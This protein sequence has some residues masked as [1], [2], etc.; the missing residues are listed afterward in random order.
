[1]PP[2]V[3]EG[4]SVPTMRVC[5]LEGNCLSIPRD[6]RDKWLLDPIRSPT[7]KDV[8]RKFDSVFTAELVVAPQLT[9]AAAA[10]EESSEVVKDE[11]VFAWGD[12]F[13][14]AATTEQDLA[15]L[16]VVASF[17]LSV[18]GAHMNI[19]EEKELYVLASEELTLPV[20]VWL[21]G[22]GAG[23][24]LQDEKASTFLN[25]PSGTGWMKCEFNSD[26]DLI[27]FEEDADSHRATDSAPHTLR[28]RFHQI[29]SKGLV[30]IRLG[31][32]S[33]QRPAAVQQGQMADR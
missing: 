4:P 11:T 22:Y 24:W 15:K 13:P 3:V 17:P 27:I 23:M 21:I 32:H 1:M 14:E 5:K 12:C 26:M 31:G 20:D 2:S 6:I 33:I 16:K 25:A 7:W 28:E 29:E 9:T 30:D 19:T 10:S 8:L 18:R